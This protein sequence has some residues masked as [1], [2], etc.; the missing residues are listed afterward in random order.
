MCICADMPNNI[1]VNVTFL[2]VRIAITRTKVQDQVNNTVNAQKLQDMFYPLLN[3]YTGKAQ[4]V[5]NSVEY[6]NLQYLKMSDSAHIWIPSWWYKKLK[7][8]LNKKGKN[9]KIAFPSDC[10]KSCLKKFEVEGIR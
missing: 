10:C 6:H 3:K 1:S 5:E 7:Q 8:F 2:Y 9:D 4:C